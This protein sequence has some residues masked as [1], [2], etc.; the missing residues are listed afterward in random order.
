MV[1]YFC[2]AVGA[3][4]LVTK[5][6]QIP[7]K[8]KSS[9]PSNISFEGVPMTYSECRRTDER[10]NFQERN[11]SNLWCSYTV[12]RASFPGLSFQKGD[13]IK[14]KQ[15][16]ESGGRPMSYGEDCSLIFY[17]PD[18]VF[19]KSFTECVQEKKGE[20]TTSVRPRCIVEIDG[21]L[22]HN[23]EIADKLIGQ[24]VAL[25]GNYSEQFGRRCYMEFVEKLNE[26]PQ[27]YNIQ[28]AKTALNRIRF[29]SIYTPNLDF[30]YR[31]DKITF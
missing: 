29:L 22:A 17:N 11:R 18:Y 9:P 1:A 20:F 14:Y 19:P 3:L 23:T 15:C 25:G 21:S 10:Y 2:I 5:F 6:W 31:A 30:R 13:E 28:H 16:T 7:T 4:F 26:S 12:A 8:I 27:T 24:C